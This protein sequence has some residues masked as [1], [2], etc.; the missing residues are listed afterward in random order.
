MGNTFQLED[1]NTPEPTVQ[2]VRVSQTP[3]RTPPRA[4]IACSAPQTQSGRHGRL[5]YDHPRSPTFEVLIG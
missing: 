2:L 3:V 4:N 1:L 5:T